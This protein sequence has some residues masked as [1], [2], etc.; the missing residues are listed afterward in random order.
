MPATTAAA[1]V[2]FP[3][4]T[5]S[6]ARALGLCEVAADTVVALL[7]N[8]ASEAGEAT[9]KVFYRER[10][11]KIRLQPRNQTMLPIIVADHEV[12]RAS[13]RRDGITLGLRWRFG[14]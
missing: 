6:G 10:G 1:E 3:N 2:A 4:L 13:Y 7:L 14:R 5:L 9:L 11:N 8:G 12:R